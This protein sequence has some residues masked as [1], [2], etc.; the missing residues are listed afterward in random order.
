MFHG[1]A[2]TRVCASGLPETSLLKKVDESFVLEAGASQHEPLQCSQSDRNQ[3]VSHFPF[4]AK[5]LNSVANHCAP[6]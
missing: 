6:S 1:R 4:H 2:A 3:K 5:G